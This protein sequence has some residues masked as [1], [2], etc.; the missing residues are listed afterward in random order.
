MSNSGPTVGGSTIV[1]NEIKCTIMGTVWVAYEIYYINSK[2]LL[3]W[4]GGDNQ[5][6]KYRNLH[7][8]IL[9]L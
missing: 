8:A 4:G 9:F 7:S 1:P 6:E 3:V 2:T 5:A